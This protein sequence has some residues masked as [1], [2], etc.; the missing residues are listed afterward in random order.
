MNNTFSIPIR[1]YV[2]DTDC[3]GIVN[4]AK[5]INFLER[6]R[7]EWLFAIDF[8]LEAYRTQNIYF[9]VKDINIQYKKPIKLGDLIDATVSIKKTTATSLTFLQTIVKDHVCYCEADV[10]VVCINEHMRPI[11]IPTPLMEK[12]K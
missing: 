7:T 9:A 11:A 3:Y 5:F 10:V 4:H 8:N 1:V 2:E 12:F 6:A